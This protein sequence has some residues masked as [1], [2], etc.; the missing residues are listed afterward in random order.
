MPPL[1]GGRQGKYLTWV[2]GGVVTIAT[3][4]DFIISP[5]VGFFL[6]WVGGEA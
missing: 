1:L 2:W 6:C 3:K 4:V 5:N